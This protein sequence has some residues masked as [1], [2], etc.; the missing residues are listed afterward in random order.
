MSSAKNIFSFE[1]IFSLK[2]FKTNIRTEIVAGITTFMS[3]AYILI[4]NPLML[5]ESGMPL[6]AAFTATVWASILPTLIMGFFAN[7]PIALAPGMGVNAFFTYT[8]VLGM[9]L[10]WENALAAV[11]VSGLLFVILA[12][13]GVPSYIMKAIPKQLKISIGVGIGFFITLIGLQNAGIVVPS[14][15]TMLELGDLSKESTLLALFG[16]IITTALM[17]KKVHGSLLWGILGITIISMLIGS[18]P[19][20]ASYKDIISTEIPSLA[21]V[22]LKLDFV[23]IMKVSFIGVILS[24]TLVDLFNAMATMVGVSTKEGMQNED[25]SMRGL[26]SATLADASGTLMGSLLG[27]SP[28]TSYLES[29]VGIEEGGRT[30]LCAITVAIL[31]FLSLLF[32]PLIQFV[33]VFATAPTLILVGVFMMLDIKNVDFSDFTE[34]VPAF[35]TMVIMPFTYS[36]IAG[37][38]F[39]FMS[40]CLIKTFVGRVKEVSPVMWIVSFCFFLEFFGTHIYELF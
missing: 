4:V 10:S 18:S 32:A 11:F 40:F 25:G 19:S 17:V 7:L 36:I 23:A 8:L 33:P 13:I 31:F 22:F 21:P 30:G 6:S 26:K 3:I 35:L 29:L 38:A 34:A 9:G 15:S 20:P 14:P 37:F 24:M 5:A 27:T 28:V 39:G 12:I 16:L 1:N 2:K